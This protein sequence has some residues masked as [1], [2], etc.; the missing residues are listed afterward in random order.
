MGDDDIDG[1]GVPNNCDTDHASAPTTD[2]FT[3]G[4]D[5]CADAPSVIEGVHTVDNTAATT[6]GPTDG[7][8]NMGN[9]V[10]FL[11]TAGGSGNATIETCGSA[12]SLDDTVLIVYDAST[13]CPVAGDLGLASDDD[14]C[15]SPNFN[16]TV[17][18]PVTG[19]NSCLL[20]TSPSPRDQR[21]SRMPSSA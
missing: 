17:T 13:G 1:D 6:D 4:A 5:N 12:G 20:Y 3:G 16:S 18:I 10:W 21:G 14:G 8:P 15:T 2:T 19:G 11:Y 9:D 7:D